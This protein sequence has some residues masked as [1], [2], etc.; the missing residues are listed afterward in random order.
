MCWGRAAA[1]V[2]F[3]RP[4]AEQ[5]SPGMYKKPAKKQENQDFRRTSIFRH[6]F[7][8]A[9]GSRSRSLFRV[10]WGRLRAVSDD[11]RSWH[12]GSDPVEFVEK[13]R[14]RG[15]QSGRVDDSMS[16]RAGGGDGNLLETTLPSACDRLGPGCGGGLRRGMKVRAL[17]QGC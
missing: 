17:P 4:K 9:R 15:I 10:F 11:P 3:V 1:V 7:L 16:W 5:I 14:F 6:F 13:S 12:L 2:K 8:T